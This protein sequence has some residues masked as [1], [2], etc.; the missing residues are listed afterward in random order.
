MIFPAEHPLWADAIMETVA[1]T[2]EGVGLQYYVMAGTLLG[3]Y[4]DDK[5]IPWDN[6]LDIG[7]HYMPEKYDELL[8]R[9]MAVGFTTDIGSQW[10][11]WHLWKHGML[12]DIIPLE[13]TSEGA[14]F[15]EQPT[16]LSHAGHKYYTPFPIDAY[17]KWKYGS[18]WRTPKQK[19]EYEHHSG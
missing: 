13:P 10:E 7:I 14:R 11:G 16:T 18:D 3:W 1:N 8:S 15:Y 9:L 12:I 4:R 5:Y 19:G 17:L 2:C 6:D